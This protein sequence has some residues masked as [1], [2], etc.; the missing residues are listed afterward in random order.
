MSAAPKY[1]PHYTVNDYLGWDGDWELWSG[2]PIA[3]SPS[4]FGRH[5]AVAS[6]VAYE[7]R[8]AIIESDCQA[9][10]LPEIDWIVS[11]DTVVRPDVVVWQ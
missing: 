3:M 1:I 10:V 8:K 11:D 2:I 9:E 6:R 7:L 5:Q 4:P